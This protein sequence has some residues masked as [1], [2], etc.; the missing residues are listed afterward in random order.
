MTRARLADDLLFLGALLLAFGVV[1][2]GFVAL[3]I[4]A[5]AED[6]LVP[7]GADLFIWPLA[8]VDG[9]ACLAMVA[10][11]AGGPDAKE[12]VGV[13]AVLGLLV[14]LGLVDGAAGW[15]GHGPAA[16]SSFPAL[17]AGAAA[18]LAAG[19]LGAVGLLLGGGRSAA[20]G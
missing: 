12:L 18:N 4:G 5:S 19:A 14:G 2:L 1:A 6:P 11:R 15:T 17:V 3:R 9:I 10:G 7:R 13:A 8:L 20:S 16:S